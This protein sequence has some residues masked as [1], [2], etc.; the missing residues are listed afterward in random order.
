LKNE[1]YIYPILV[2]LGIAALL[3]FKWDK[4]FL[5]FFWDEAW[6]Y[7]PAV[8]TMAE[9]G[10]CLS[11]GCISQHLHTGHPLLFYFSAA[12]WMTIFGISTAAGHAFAM[13]VSVAFLASVYYVLSKLINQRMAFIAFLFLLVQPVFVALSS[14]MLAEIFLSLIAI[15]TLYFYAKKK[16]FLFVI[17]ASMLVST[18]E[19]GFIFLAAIYLHYIISNFKSL[20]TLNGIKNGLVVLIPFLIGC[21]FFIV[22][23]IKFGWYFFPRHL[24]WVD[25]DFDSL[26]KKGATVVNFLFVD[27][28]RLMFFYIATPILLLLSSSN[29]FEQKRFRYILP[30]AS[31]IFLAFWPITTTMVSLA[32]TIVFSLKNSSTE[33]KAF[34]AVAGIFTFGYILFSA[35]NF[36]SLRYLY[37][38]F[39]MIAL[40][41]AIVL[42]NEKYKYLA[43]AFSIFIGINGYL[44]LRDNSK[45]NNVW[46]ISLT[47]SK[48]VEVHQDVVDYILEN[49]LKNERILTHGLVYT[50]FTNPM[51]GYVSKDMEPLKHINNFPADSSE[52]VIYSC[53]EQDAK[54]KPIL[55]NDSLIKLVEFKDGPAWS[56]IYRRVMEE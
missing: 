2:L 14:F 51:A 22:Q 45:V 24:N 28:G 3:I 34:L 4:L 55:E 10:P 43:V 30:G 13:T 41:I 19:S 31:L 33:K 50:A 46:G 52:I 44:S 5:P 48:M 9:S 16:W 25:P 32:L 36:L 8:M 37:I 38:I 56:V 47:Y 23:K 54:F 29:Y 27:Q 1:K 20:F 35:M 21:S 18:K 11:P 40:V 15:W 7:G 53:I 39:P 12:T 26:L 49:D 17:L 6:V 42:S